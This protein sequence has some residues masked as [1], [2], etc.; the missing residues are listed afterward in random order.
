MMQCPVSQKCGGCAMLGMEYHDQLDHKRAEVESL[1]R[2]RG[3]GSS[4][5][6]VCGMEN[7]WY[8][9]NKVIAN[10]SMK[11][12]RISYGMYE[13]NT[14]RVVY[15]P[16]CL[17]QNKSL[18]GILADLKEEMDR[19]HIKAYGF[20]GVL[21]QILL[22]I[23]I[24]TGQVLVVFVT[25]DDL[26]HGR[27]DLVKRITARHKEIR[28]IVQNTNPRDTSVVLS[29]REKVIYGPGFI[30]DDILGVRFKISARS[31]YQI[32]PEQTQIL[33]SKAIELAGIGPQDSVMD[34]YCGIGTIGLCAASKGAGKVIGVEINRDAVRD[35]ISN[36]KYNGVGNA[37]FFCAD[38]KKF[39]ADF[40][41]P[42]DVL[43]LDP[44][45][46]GCDA[47]FLQSVRRLHPSR[48]VYISCNPATQARDVAALSGMYEAGDSYPV[49]M[50]PHTAHIENI[51]PLKLRCK[52]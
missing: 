13:E 51:I 15:A 34:A 23:G 52:A 29:D 39:M 8:Y 10:I 38:V 28:T 20:G 18:N 6:P 5:H 9:R 41:S 26:F 40:D 22:R 7:P 32:N 1:L 35:A 47:A 17:L 27:A 11:G 42:V 50:F 21:K 45:R 4:V 24:S 19:L 16:D 36:A 44:P 49:D 3:I 33:Y 12:G 25:S 48:I 2:A 46:D 31:F 30:T 43:I 37:R 14:H